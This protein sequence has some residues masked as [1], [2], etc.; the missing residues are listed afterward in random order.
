MSIDLIVRA[1]TRA[2][3]GRFLTAPIFNGRALAREIVDGQPIMRPFL[4]VSPWRGDGRFIVA[5]AVTDADG[6]IITPEQ[7]LPG[8][9]LLMRVAL[10]DDDITDENEDE[11][12][13]TDP[14]RER[15]W[16]RSRVAR[17]MRKAGTLGTQAGI[18]YFE[19]NGTNGGSY[20]ARVYDGRAVKARLETLGVGGH[21]W[22]QDER[23]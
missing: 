17:I 8:Y 6:N 2:Q 22:A 3:M 20:T 14:D 7:T 9:F 16:N 1:P 15:S 12:D 5:E 13:A 4:D 23:L 21:Q 19:F 18:P 10:P 11:P